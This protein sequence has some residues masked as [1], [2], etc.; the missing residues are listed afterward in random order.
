[1]FF[2]GFTDTTFDFQPK[3]LKFAG[4]RGRVQHTPPMAANYFHH[5]QSLPD[6]PQTALSGATFTAQYI[7]NITEPVFVY[8]RVY[9]HT[10]CRALALNYVN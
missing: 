7:H 4:F 3:G 2:H 6:N 5:G 1:M 8:V 10:L 9:K